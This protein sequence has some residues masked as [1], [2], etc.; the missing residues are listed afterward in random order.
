LFV[1]I[2]ATAALSPT[3][4]MLGYGLSKVGAHH[5]I[6]SLGETT[7]K[8]ATTKSR[9]QKAR[10]LR[11]NSAYLD[12]LSVVGILPTTIDTPSNREAMPDADFNQWTQPAHIAK[13]IGTWI[14]TPPLRPHSGSLVKVHPDNNGGAT[15]NLVR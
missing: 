8:S 11:K 14:R 9:R 15:F 5:F 6:Q 4:G 10:R 3:P 1:V 13:E 2:G 12:T 7:G